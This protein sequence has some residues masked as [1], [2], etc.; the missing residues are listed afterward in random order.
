[1]SNVDITKIYFFNK[2]NEYDNAIF[3]NGVGR[4]CC[5]QGYNIKRNNSNISVLIYVL[6]GRGKINIDSEEFIAGVGD[7]FILPQNTSQDYCTYGQKDWKI[8]W[9]NIEGEL[10]SAMIEAYKINFYKPFHFGNVEMEALFEKGVALADKRT[11]TVNFQMKL[12]IIISEI[13]IRMGNYDKHQTEINMTQDTFTKIKEYIDENICQ[14]L[15]VK[16]LES[17]F[18]LS[19]KQIGRIFKSG[20]GSTIYEYYIN[21]KIYLSCKYLEN[22]SL[23]IKEISGKLGF[24]DQYYFSN[25][26]KKH[27]HRSPKIYRNIR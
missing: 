25:F 14:N 4:E 23:S 9:F 21:Q 8:L 18:H 20:S 11:N 3:V 27:M 5:S 24:C 13:L 15:T 10:V 26:F 12:S 6:D 19:Q 17:V 22:T 7:V 16:D 2:P 1:M